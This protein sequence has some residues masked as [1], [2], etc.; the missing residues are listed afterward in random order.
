[1]NDGY[2]AAIASIQGKWSN[3][4]LAAFLRDLSVETVGIRIECGHDGVLRLLSTHARPNE[5]EQHS[6]SL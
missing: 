5:G 1:M 4:D 6:A 3:D 2:G